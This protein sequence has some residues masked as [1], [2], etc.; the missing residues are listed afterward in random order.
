M[1][2]HNARRLLPPTAA[3]APR[4]RRTRARWFS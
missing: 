1:F 4:G 3:A 2:G